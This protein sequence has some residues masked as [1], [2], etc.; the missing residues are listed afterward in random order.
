MYAGN[1]VILSKNGQIAP[2]SLNDFENV[3]DPDEAI[4]SKVGSAVRAAMAA[5]E[6][7]HYSITEALD[8]SSTFGYELGAEDMKSKIIQAFEVSD[9]ACSAWAIELI[10]SSLN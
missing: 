6:D 3:P 2:M 4:V 7:L 10:E 9:S 8:S 5:K 1:T